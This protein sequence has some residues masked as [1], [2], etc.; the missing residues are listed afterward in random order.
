MA[1]FKCSMMFHSDIYGW[2]ETFYREDTDYTSAFTV[3]RELAEKRHALNGGGVSLDYVRI[4]DDAIQRDAFVSA[5]G[6]VTV[7]PNQSQPDTNVPFIRVQ[8]GIP[9]QPHS[10][11]LVRIEATALYHAMHC[12][13]G[14]PDAL[15]VWPAGPSNLIGW[16]EAFRRWRDYLIGNFR[17]KV[18]KQDEGFTKKPINGARIDLGPP[19][20]WQL[21]AQGYAPVVGD[22]LRVTN[23]RWTRGSPRING[24]W[25]VETVN[26]G[27]AE[28]TL[29]NF[30][31]PDGF[32]FFAPTRPLTG[33]VQL[34]GWAYPTITA[35]I[36]RGE[37]SRKPGRP[38]GQQPGRRLV[39]R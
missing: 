21:H 8:W 9:D 3:F 15:I 27:T 29:A 4:S 32:N 23:F 28:F 5:P 11:V 26:A 19:V 38:F 36:I 33:F 35:A 20:T 17:I 39:R 13:R 31:K 25:Q 1:T 7:S 30:P 16:D 6:E 37:S 12:L 18:R 10:G 24:L 14:V 22:K 34:V 2:S